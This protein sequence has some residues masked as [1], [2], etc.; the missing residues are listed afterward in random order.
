MSGRLWLEVEDLFEYAAHNPRLSGI[1]RVQFELFRALVALDPS[2]TRIGF[3]RHDPKNLSLR[4]V[5]W[6][7]V[8]AVGRRLRNGN[9]R[10]EGRPREQTSGWRR[11]IKHVVSRLPTRLHQPLF[12]FLLDQRAAIN[13]LGR[14]LRAAGS[15]APRD[16]PSARERRDAGAFAAFAR[17]G[18]V[19]LTTGAVWYQPDYAA[20]IRANCTARGVRFSLL[21]H[22]IIPIRRPEWCDPCQARLFR[23][24][25]D[26]VLGLA[27]Q[28]L[29]V[30]LASAGDIERYA[31]E[32]GRPLPGRVRVVP[33]GSGFETGRAPEPATAPA[34]PLPA[35][36]SYALIVSTIEA[37]KNHLLLFRVWR[38]LLDDMPAARVPT[39]VFAGRIGWMV[40]DLFQ[41]L[42]NCDFLD[43]KI[44][45]LEEPDDAELERLY[46]GCMFTLFPSF[47]E[48]WGLPATESLAFGRPC[49]ISNTTSLPE[50]GGKLARYF[51]PDS[52]TD[53]YAVIRDALS[54]PP[55]LAAWR[56]QVAAQF[57]PVSWRETATVLLDA[58][59]A[60]A[61]AGDASATKSK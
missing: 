38:R 55:A 43:G 52:T 51:D 9:T 46:E 34:R 25:F 7:D 6:A 1:Q 23:A 3:V 22:D 54:D 29:S 4:I 50:A 5:P 36:G 32:Q 15:R 48:G 59:Q 33:L 8:E 40:A 30:S 56:A 41:Q 14:L 17:P 24:W 39:L 27:D 31:A 53:A 45:L 16:D 2:G 58:V 61:P 20:L 28:L 19:F 35:P 44:V 42:R 47:H 26:K 60:A 12:A 21:V 10:P 13:S 49:I 37:R 18:D 57:R 11:S